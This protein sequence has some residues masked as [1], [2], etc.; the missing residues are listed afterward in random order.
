MDYNANFFLYR[1]KFIELFCKV[2][3]SRHKFF[4]KYFD[5]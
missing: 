3:L 5:K 4:T 2:I 1:E